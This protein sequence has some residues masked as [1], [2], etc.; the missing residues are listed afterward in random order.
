MDSVSQ[1]PVYGDDSLI[2]WFPDSIV[3]KN[4]TYKVPGAILDAVLDLTL[5]YPG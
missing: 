1:Y 2:S 5:V 4:N 3:H